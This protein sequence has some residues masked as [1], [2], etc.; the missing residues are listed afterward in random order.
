MSA[1]ALADNKKTE[2]DLQITLEDIN[3][4]D[5]Y[6]LDLLKE[7]T[8]QAELRVTDENARKNRIDMRMSILL[9]AFVGLIGI[10][11]VNF[12]YD[13]YI[14]LTPIILLLGVATGYLIN[15]LKSQ[16]YAPLGALPAPWLREELIKDYGNDK[17]NNM[18]LGYVWS[19]MLYGTHK[20]LARSDQSNSE[21]LKLLNKALWITQL[22]L[23]PVF[24]FTVYTICSF[25][26]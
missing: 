5:N 24:L 4:I 7:A 18:M 8:R 13:N 23:I 19:H 6:N 21:R 26:I 3:K 2:W 14:V 16:F 9:S 25:F 10:M 12:N 15:G 22:A 1:V 20:A 17:D 11:V